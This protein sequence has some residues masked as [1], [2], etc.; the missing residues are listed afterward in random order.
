MY[1]RGCYIY[2][3]EKHTK[4]NSIISSLIVKDIYWLGLEFSKMLR[5][6]EI[7]EPDKDFMMVVIVINFLLVLIL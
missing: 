3:I 5:C 1:K 4:I 6:L 7:V 2:R